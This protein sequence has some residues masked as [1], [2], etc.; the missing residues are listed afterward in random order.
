MSEDR[1]RDYWND[2]A[3]ES[4]YDKNLVDI[5]A[6]AIL[7]Y[8]GGSDHVM[9]IGCGE[10]ESTVRY[11]EK[12]KEL[13]AVDYSD[14][15]LEKLK[16]RNPGI[17]TI[18]ADMRQLKSAGI[19]IRVTK[20]I[21]Q[22]SL[23]NLESFDEQA[24][25]IR[26]IHSMLAHDGYYLMLEGFSEGSE[27][28]NWARTEFGLPRIEVKWHNCFFRKSQLV[29]FIA[30]Y[31]EIEA[32]RDFSMYFFLTRVFNAILRHPEQPRWDDPVNRLAKAM[33]IKFKNELIKGI[34]RLE[35]MVLKKRSI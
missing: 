16:Q 25:V 30:P 5:E 18:Q 3:V 14:V 12:V 21:T 20:A 2:S 33:E 19:G 8:L 31:F 32:E 34:S 11:A 13:V 28:I 7:N 23:I 29:E 27:A 35:L 9:D 10:G 17:R 6:E 26:D 4:M 24:N 15:R 1:I 22:R